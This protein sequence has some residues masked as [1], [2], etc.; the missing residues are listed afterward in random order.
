LK[1]KIGHNK[2]FYFPAGIVDPSSD[3]RTNLTTEANHNHRGGGD[4]IIQR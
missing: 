1:Q 4:E 2:G 3:K